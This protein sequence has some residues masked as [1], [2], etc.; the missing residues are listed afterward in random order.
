MKHL[1]NLSS[2]PPSRTSSI[3]NEV[4]LEQPISVLLLLSLLIALLQSL[5]PSQASTNVKIG[6]IGVQYP[7][8]D[9]SLT[10]QQYLPREH[11]LSLSV[12]GKGI[13]DIESNG[14]I[15]CLVAEGSTYCWGG[16]AYSG[17]FASYDYQLAN[18][19]EISKP[20]LFGN[21]KFT[22][23]SVGSN[24]VCGIADSQ[25][26]CWGNG[27]NGQ[28]GNGG[29]QRVYSP[30]PVSTLGLLSGKSVTDI[31]VGGSH[32]CAV[33]DA[34]AYCWGYNAYGQLGD[35][36]TTSS[37]SPIA[38]L[39]S[40]VL[41]NKIVTAIS[42]SDY[43]TCAIASGSLFC[44]GN[45]DNGQLGNG[46]STSSS[47]PVAVSTSGA[48][49]G[50]TVTAIDTSANHTCAVASAAV[51]CWGYNYSGLLGN[52]TTTA[53][54]SPV[55]VATSGVL[56]GKTVTSISVSS[57]HTCAVASGSVFC[58]GYN[59]SG[60]LGNGTRSSSSQPVAV[61]T[62][63]ALASKKVT[64]IST[65][66]QHSCAAT[67]TEIFC[68]GDNSN[69]QLGDTTK[70]DSASPVKVMT[71]SS[72]SS[73][74]NF[75]SVSFDSRNSSL[76]FVADNQSYS[77]TLTLD[78]TLNSKQLTTTD[79]LGSLNGKVISRAAYGYGFAC[80]LVESRVYCAGQQNTLG[81]L[82]NGTQAVS[83]NPVEID[84]T[85]VLKGLAITDLSAG[86]AHAC[87]IAS[88]KVFCWGSNSQGQLGISDA[89][90]ST[91]AFK[92]IASLSPI[93]VD[94]TGV[95]S[96]DKAVQY[97]TTSEYSTCVV[98]A[99]QP[100]CWGSFVS[101][102][103][104][105]ANSYGAP[106]SMTELGEMVGKKIT[107][108]AIPRSQTYFYDQVISCA[109]TIDGEGYC[110]GNQSFNG[111]NS[112][113]N[114]PTK[115]DMVEIGV[116][117][118]TDVEV[119]YNFGCALALGQMYCWGN[120]SNGQLGTG[121][122][123]DV[124]KPK[125]VSQAGILK[126]KEVISIS[127]LSNSTYFTYRSASTALL[128]QRKVVIDAELKAIADAKAAAALELLNATNQAKVDAE[129]AARERLL[130]GE[131]VQI[132][133]TSVRTVS[134][135]LAG[136][137]NEKVDGALKPHSLDI[138]PTFGGRTATSI[139]LGTSFS[140]AIAGGAP[141]CWGI[142]NLGQLGNGTAISRAVPTAVQLPE[143]LKGKLITHMSVGGNTACV[144]VEG[145][146]YC[147]G[148]NSSGQL[149][150]S[151]VSYSMVPIAVDTS[152]ALKSLKISSIDVGETHTCAIASSKAIC[153]GSN[154]YSQLGNSKAK[155]E[156]IFTPTEVDSDGVLKNKVL[157]TVAVGSGHTCVATINELFCWGIDYNGQL[158]SGTYG[159]IKE[160]KDVNALKF[161][162]ASIKQITGIEASSNSTCVIADALLYC[163]GQ[164]S[165]GRFDST[166]VGGISKP[167]QIEM[168]GLLLGREIQEVGIGAA[169]L[170]VLASSAPLCW[171]D[172]AQ[173][174][175][176]TGTEISSFTPTKVSS[177]IVKSGSTLDL[178]VSTNTSCAIAKG[179]VY[180]WGSSSQ[181]QGGRISPA[182][183]SL[184]L[185]VG[186]DSSELQF[187]SL[188]NLQASDYRSFTFVAEGNPYD[189][190]P[191][192]DKNLSPITTPILSTNLGVLKGKQISGYSNESG[193][194]CFL[195]N[196]EIYCRGENA[197]GQ[198]GNN[199]TLYSQEPVKVD[200]TGVLKGKKINDFALGNSHA[201]VLSENEVFCWGN[202]E[203]GQLGISDEKDAFGAYRTQF[204]NK[205][206]AIDTTGVLKGKKI[207]DIEAS[208]Q[209]TC[210]VAS[211]ELFCWGVLHYSFKNP[212]VSDTIS[213]GTAK[214]IQNKGELSGK[215]ITKLILP[216][217]LY[218]SSLICAL[219][220]NRAYCWS[221]DRSTGSMNKE[222]TVPH[223]VGDKTLVA[224][225]V[226][227][228]A[229]S[230]S[231]ACLIS[232]GEVF[233]W[234]ENSSGQLGIGNVNS[235]NL[236]VQMDG[237]TL[238]KNREAF[239]IALSSNSTM[240]AHRELT[241]EK[242]KVFADLKVEIQKQV[243]EEEERLRVLAEAEAKVKADALRKSELRAL[244]SNLSQ[245]IQNISQNVMALRA[246]CE[247]ITGN[248]S[249]QQRLAIARTSIST[250]CDK[251]SDSSNSLTRELSS[252]S[253]EDVS[254]SNY[255]SKISLLN[256]VTK[257]VGV[258]EETYFSYFNEKM[259]IGSDFENLI[260]LEDLYAKSAIKDLRSWINL[261][262][263][264]Q[265][266]PSS[267]RKSI[268]EKSSY[269]S[270]LTKVGIIET[271]QRSFE[272]YRSALSSVSS[273][274]EI[275]NSA[276]QLAAIVASLEKAENLFVDISSV[277]KLIPAFVCTKGS[278]VTALP[279]NGKCL[280]GAKK[281]ATK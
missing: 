125:L 76:R 44:W 62:S 92:T 250:N 22:K 156:S 188:T 84:M 141:Y 279:K 182:T 3:S 241:A 220:D 41:A 268:S 200:T 164:N 231:H 165:S 116:R 43:H 163:W 204:S 174:Q 269:Q 54:N 112:Q 71:S 103:H 264:V 10:S 32:V 90:D 150:V 117:K 42:A 237:G 234:G 213:S 224:R 159:S 106:L 244:Q 239:A 206:V 226:S 151:G 219:A 83:T 19:T 255:Q 273:S 227:E 161:T 142:N 96:K 128:Q 97:L 248:L 158:G 113:V 205:P 223:I 23:V 49:A 4:K 45:N 247:S 27:S 180:C 80:Y 262:A 166:T 252:I 272:S 46:S 60:Q 25:A 47:T 187:K 210:V 261:E 123:Q 29:S 109:I 242:A 100:Y 133:T 67:Q 56:S 254:E 108:I 256:S 249:A 48:L 154:Q 82:G 95:L 236:P 139:H 229:M 143:K 193:F 77:Q 199:S 38:V 39:T 208:S 131:G 2:F 228:L 140:C 145:E 258:I 153:W 209:S 212:K 177:E 72:A 61:L 130:Y 138:P 93:A 119:G 170:C 270:A 215:K 167:R 37:N 190:N 15:N 216:P 87:V 99:S 70:T 271:A 202:N 278:T 36:T 127:L 197:Y 169:H 126:D 73:A 179:R 16:P 155:K 275:S 185:P 120:N 5:T 88:A 107:K 191:A 122:K 230:N 207:T 66:Y 280:A 59:E 178:A 240:I 214:E 31:S 281:T 124:S 18:P 184:P 266:L 28:I 233:C 118:I 146:A 98:A 17:E 157:T 194:Q 101:G 196:S 148:N 238:L 33:A 149:G 225:P 86:Y 189:F 144:V 277:G 251:Y 173:G 8:N 147:W 79:S 134:L 111:G 11:S 102:F 58:W 221:G 232:M 121:E 30:T 53:S 78:S 192:V 104:K 26:Y 50:K 235:Q 218:S 246:K 195:F 94:T 14:S 276:N 171:G 260:Y 217:Q 135:A 81:Q 13:S 12:N 253:V 201:C 89:R 152:G 172:N 203:S 85:G 136:V 222:L 52:G 265:K 20:A 57:N 168:N 267:I 176:G 55:A 64:Q 243:A 9:D 34:K 160:I 183:S 263:R 69:Y 35:G 162:T 245:R 68:W 21:K 7:S 175:L 24:T 1:R 259:K 105:N 186:V 91:N 274:R 74:T 65:G 181:Y 114:T 40:G 211:D 132:P 129:A 6:V 198:L 75:H 257:Q 137:T 63:G 51:Y 115:L 110:W